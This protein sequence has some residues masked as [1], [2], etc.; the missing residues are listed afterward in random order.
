MGAFLDAV[1]RGIAEFW[2]LAAEVARE[3]ILTA[4]ALAVMTSPVGEPST[5]KGRPPKNYK[6][7]QF[8]SNWNLGVDAIDTT[9]TSKTDVFTVNGLGEMPDQLFGHRIYLSNASPQAWRI[10]MDH[11]SLQAP[12][13]VITPI[14]GQ[15]MELFRAAALKVKGGS[16]LGPGER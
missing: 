2:I 15:F 13:G 8:R 1:D 16:H 11:W 7:G 12:N 3:T 6:P 9:H 10:E 4:G 14:E 5:W